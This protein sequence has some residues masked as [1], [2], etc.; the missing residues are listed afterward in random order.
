MNIIVCI[1]QVPDTTE[2]RINPETNT[3]IREGVETIINPFDMYAIEEGVRLKEKHGGR[4]PS[5]R[6]G[7]PAGRERPAR[8]HRLGADEAVLLSDRAFAGAD[9]WPPP[10]RWPR[11]SASSAGSRPGHLR[12]AGHRRRH[13]AGRPR[14]RREP[15]HP[16]R[17]LRAEDRGD[18]RTATSARAHDRRWLPTSSRRRC[19]AVITVVKEINEPRLPSLRGKMSAKK[20]EITE[21][22]PRTH[23]GR[24]R[25]ARG[26]QR[27]AD[28][29]GPHLHAAQAHGGQGDHGRAARDVAELPG[30]PQGRG[31]PASGSGR[32][33]KNCM[34]ENPIRIVAENCTGC[35]LCEKACPYDAI[36]VVEDVRGQAQAGRGGR[37]QVHPLRRLRAG[38]QVRRHHHQPQ[39]LRRPEHRHLL[40]HRRVRRAPRWPARLGGA[41][42]H[43]RRRRS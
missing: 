22:G 27:L 4:S 28:A 5:S 38:V 16:A 41:R 34:D 8:G 17:H 20:A 9:T 36:H 23:L 7:P 13:R 12:Q 43:R 6:M 24:R 30:G 19:P 1:K 29:G 35:K 42:D 15:R 11:A 25:R 40:G 37:R 33:E 31:H 39:H 18:R 14:P 3:L 2:V 10:T 26:P 21:S 32:E